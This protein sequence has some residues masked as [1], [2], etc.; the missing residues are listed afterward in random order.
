MAEDA[1]VARE[2]NDVV[3]G[4]EEVLVAQFRDQLEFPL[5]EFHHLGRYTFRPA[6]LRTGCG[7]LAQM[8]RWRQSRRHE[9]ARIFVAQFV[10]AKRAALG[11]GHGFEKHL[12][13]IDRR[14]RVQRLQV[15]FR[16]LIDAGAEIV[17]RSLQ[18]DS[19]QHV[20]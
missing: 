18:T 2:A 13:G 3:D 7:E 17:Y 20:L 1:V 11:D 6:L 5:H 15:A 16:V 19:R 4:E 8:D 14:Q 10:H 12:P 9:L